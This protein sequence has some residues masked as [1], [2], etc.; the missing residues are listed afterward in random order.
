MVVP[1]SESISLPDGRTLAFATYGDPDGAPLFFHHGTPG[2]SHLGALLSEPALSRGVRVIAPSRPGYGRSD[3]NSDGTFETWA[4]DCR[5]LADSLELESFAVA[6]FSGGGPY[7]L[8]VAA[9]HADRVSAV[10]IVGA[11]VPAHDGG[12]F[13]SLVRFP[14]LLGIAF[15]FGAVVARFRGDRFVVDQLTDRSVDDETARIVG[16]DFRVGLSAGP[17]GAVRES[18]A[19]ATDWSL[20][21]PDGNVTVWHGVDDENAPIGPV[22]TAYGDRP[23]VT[24]REVDDDHLGTLCSVRD[25]VVGLA[26]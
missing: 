24:L 21:L 19:L 26:D 25:P 17:S 4:D 16:R 1:E 20:P 5:A 12:P 15:R 8:A 9:R 23:N 13:G 11:P 18:S 22:R 6:G 14:R 3:P 2:S 7:A 10:G